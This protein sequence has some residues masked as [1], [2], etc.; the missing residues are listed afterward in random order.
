MLLATL[1]EIPSEARDRTVKILE[2]Q[3]KKGW[4]GVLVLGEPNEPVLGVPVGMDRFGIC[5]VGGIV[6]GAAMVEEGNH[7]V[8]FA[9]HCFVPIQDMTR[10]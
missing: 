10:I 8:T 7:E 1:R 9:P 3:Q 2:E 6:P 4:G 5:M